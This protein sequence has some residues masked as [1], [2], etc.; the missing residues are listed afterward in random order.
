[1]A[2][3]TSGTIDTDLNGSN[4]VGMALTTEKAI[5][6]YV[7]SKTGNHDKHEIGL[8]VSPDGISFIDL[9]QRLIGVGCMTIEHNAEHVKAKVFKAEDRTSTVTVHIVAR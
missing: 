8:E 7:F 3:S 6:L 4:G 5:T 9:P 2:N 1:M